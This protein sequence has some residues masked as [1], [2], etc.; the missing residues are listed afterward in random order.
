MKL[1]SITFIVCSIAASCFPVT[2]TQS[3]WFIKP[4]PDSPCPG[5]NDQCYTFS[6]VLHSDATTKKLFSTNSTL[7]FLKGDHELLDFK[8][9][10]PIISHLKS[11]TLRGSSEKIPSI[12]TT[13]APSSRIVCKSPFAIAFIN[14]S[15]LS[16]VNL[17]FSNCGANITS[18]LARTAFSDQTHGIHYFGDEQK[19]ALL[20]INVR[21]FQME[22][23]VVEKSY[24]Y[25]LVGINVLGDSTVIQNSI[26]FANNNYTVSVDRCIFV[27]SSN[28]DI[29]A[30]SG[31]N[32]LFV[33]EDLLECPSAQLKHTL[34][35]QH[36]VFILAVNPYGGRL[37][38]EYLTRGAG[39]AIVLSQSS[40][41]VAV[42]LR[43]TLMHANSALLG[44][45]LY[46]AIYETV[47]NSSVSM[48]NVTSESAN[49][50][51][52]SVSNPDESTHRGG[53]H[54]DYNLPINTRNTAA[55]P[56][57]NS[58]M[59]HQ[60]EVLSM[61]DCRFLSNAAI[62]GAGAYIE[63][64]ASVFEHMPMFR[65]ERCTFSD[66]V[67]ASGMALYISQ[68][69]SFYSITTSQIIFKDVNITSNSYIT[70]IRNLTKLYTNFQ[71]NAIQ[72]I[73]TE[74]VS[75]MN[76]IFEG[77]EGSA[78]SAF[79]VSIFMSGTNIFTGNSGIIGGGI[80]LQDSRLIFVPHTL[81][82]FRDN[83]ALQHGGAINIIQQ[84][85]VNFPCFFQINDI[86]F[87]SD[88]NI[89][90]YF[91]DNYAQEAGS[92]LYGGSVDRCIVSTQSSFHINT[93]SEVFDYLVK[94]GPHRS[95]TSLIASDSTIVC[96]C[97]NNI[98]NCVSRAIGISLAPGA[99][100]IIPFVTVGQREGI[101]PSSV[102]ST[103][104][105]NTT[106]G[107]LQLIQQV[108]KTCTQLNFTIR[109]TSPSN[110]SFVVR[111]GGL[112]V[113]GNF[114]VHVQLLPCP[115][116]FILQHSGEC[117]CDPVTQLDNYNSVC[118]IDNQTVHREAGS[119]I[120]ASF[121]GPNGSY[122]GLIV[123]LN[124]PFDYC[125]QTAS[126]VD[127]LDPDSQCDYNHTGV[128]CGACKPGLSRD[129]SSSQCMQC[130][131]S[132]LA[133][134][135]LYVGSG[136]ILVALLYAL[137]LTLTSGTVNGI[138]FYAN[139]VH[140]NS[141]VFY[142]SSYGFTFIVISWL[143]LNPG[144][145]F[146]LY[147]G[148]DSYA[149]IWLTSTY[150]FYIWLLVFLVIIVSRCSPA[151]TRISGSRSVPVLATLI[152]LSYTKLLETV[153]VSLAAISI[154]N[155]DGTFRQVWFRDG[156]LDYW[157]GKH[158]PLGIFA[159]LV[160]L[161]FILPYTMLLVFVPLPCVQAQSRRRLFSW[162]NKLKPFIDAHQAPFK[163]N[164]RN[165]I[166]ILLLIRLILIFTATIGN[167]IFFKTDFLLLNI[168]IAMFLLVAVAWISKG[169]IY[170]KWQLNILE[171]SFFLNIGVLSAVTLYLKV[172]GREQ[173]TQLRISGWIVVIQLMGIL[174]YHCYV[175][176]NKLKRFVRM[177]VAMRRK[178]KKSEVVAT[179]EEEDLLE[180]PASNGE[181]SS[182]TTTTIGFADLRESLLEDEH[183]ITLEVED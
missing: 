97:D 154:P 8:G 165:W 169:G 17:A 37:P 27:P 148:A 109:T 80:S 139:I 144:L 33:Y 42:T 161:V 113:N 57:C 91:Q 73:Q 162:I 9:A 11:L 177:K 51:L 146:C 130:S 164:F 1:V 21:S 81:V 63:I 99:T 147:D 118:S 156:N 127:L 103:V 23:C 182:V 176:V 135:L 168:M 15:G 89:T 88:P 52:L 36:S 64:R 153:V 149:L 138:I 122:D 2:L 59:K 142:P 117:A 119:W 178:F 124:C 74:K 108:G 7:Y 107:E 19:A 112:A 151:L 68:Q 143:N 98:P 53:L 171:C 24:G 157:K 4:T 90:L 20:L 87:L 105:S 94:V 134:L 58:S 167:L 77:N 60:E 163:N 114:T 79:E 170:K 10:F 56:V 69:E 85:D 83:F 40:Y 6:Q 129:M 121:S 140:N 61:T 141:Y 150:P 92:L 160:L 25:G 28:S 48:E 54:F 111:T 66:N 126:D 46:I 174:G 71:L 166:G 101:T 155:P 3:E 104:V 106:L 172:G 179:P 110:T 34:L 78:L 13:N 75:F 45:N 43:N 65:I 49:G 86:D 82:V 100:I 47:D 128:L 136:V 70:P 22:S 145:E 95:D 93:S 67:G 158:V 181:T 96:V 123:V 55:A 115:L 39:L 159:I 137:N 175:E 26:F 41:A 14:I 116:G 35:I 152:L 84:S 29:T 120:N 16:F 5:P 76:C 173:D 38:D 72:L 180:L 44:A 183:H 125:L 102:Y 31:G 30:C 32:A 132:N 18:D 133:L 50:G 131:N 12:V 62:L